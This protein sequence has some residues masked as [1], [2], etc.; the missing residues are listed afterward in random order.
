MFSILARYKTRGIP[1][2]AKTPIA[3]TDVSVSQ[4]PHDTVSHFGYEFELPWNDVDGAKSRGVGTI[5]VT[6]FRSGNAFWFSKFGPREF[7]SNVVDK[8]KISPDRFQELYGKEALASDYGLMSAMLQVTPARINPFMSQR[9]AAGWTVLLLIK[10]IAVP[11][12]ASGIF[13]I[14][15]G[16]FRGFQFGDPARRPARI[17]DDLYREDGGV[18][19]I[20]WQGK[21]SPAISQAEINRILQSIRKIPSPPI[22]FERESST[23][24]VSDGGGRTIRQSE[25][26][27]QKGV[28]SGDPNR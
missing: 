9:E 7:V 8:M 24:E 13:S 3:L 18:E 2:A 21:G 22:A 25:R 6:G 20:F 14:H 17:V 26:L 4:V 16:D 5:Y 27:H 1:E 10:S 15:T 12:A 23:G 11:Q 28:A 19:L